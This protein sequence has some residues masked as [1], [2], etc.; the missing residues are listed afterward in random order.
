MR[1]PKVN[2]LFVQSFP[3]ELELEPTSSPE[4]MSVHL[5]NGCGFPLQV[6]QSKLIVEP[7]ANGVPGIYPVREMAPGGTV[8]EFGMLILLLFRLLCFA[9]PSTFKATDFSTGTSRNG[10][11]AEHLMSCLLCEVAMVMAISLCV[12]TSPFC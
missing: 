11:S 12:S 9:S 7:N 5:T 6:E 2:V 10:L 3:S 4:V 1:G 8:G